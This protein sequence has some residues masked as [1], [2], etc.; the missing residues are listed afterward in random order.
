VEEKWRSL[1][2]SRV[3]PHLEFI[4]HAVWTKNETLTFALSHDESTV[5]G[6]TRVTEKVSELQGL[7]KVHGLDFDQ[8]LSHHVSV[9]DFVIVKMNIEGAEIPVLEKLIATGHIGL[10]DQLYVEVRHSLFA[11]C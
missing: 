5:F 11:D 8:W 2:Q 10:I 1:I 9:D 3:Y 6:S 7:T 4:N